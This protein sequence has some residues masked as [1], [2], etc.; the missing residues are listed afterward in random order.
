MNLG[1]LGAMGP[2]VAPKAA[3]SGIP[4][5]GSFQSGTIGG[6]LLGATA[7]ATTVSS[8]ASPGDLGVKRIPFETDDGHQDDRK[9]L[10]G[11]LENLPAAAVSESRNWWLALKSVIWRLSTRL[12][13]YQTTKLDLWYPRTQGSVG[14]WASHPDGPRFQLCR[15]GY[16]G[17]F[18]KLDV[19]QAFHWLRGIPPW[20]ARKSENQKIRIQSTLSKA[21]HLLCWFLRVCYWRVLF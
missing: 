11:V 12:Q 13:D 14:A 19:L 9:E 3:S 18:C 21:K 15:K 2:S 1:Y 4:Q 10:G 8:T 16:L 6:R 5:L 20:H 17:P 7:T